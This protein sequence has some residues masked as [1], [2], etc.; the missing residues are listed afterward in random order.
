M[1]KPYIGITG[2][3]SRSEVDAILAEVPAELNRQIMIGV[4]ASYKTLQHFKN[5]MPNRYPELEKIGS[6]FREHPK[7]LNLIHYNTKERETLC[8]QLLGLAKIVGPNLHGFQLNIS[9]PEPK[10]LDVFHLQCDQKMKIVLQIGAGAFRKVDDSPEKL[11]RK[12]KAEYE[13]LIDYV[14]LDPSG[15]A[16]KQ[17]DP[18]KAKEYLD[19]LIDVNVNAA[20]GVAGG[21]NAETLGPVATLAIHFP[22]LCIDAEGRLRDKDDNLDLTLALAYLRRARNIFSKF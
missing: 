13:G 11:A 18:E 12:V 15:G 6:I 4:L 20:L 3:M 14:L 16:G 21:L 5:S 9:W 10:E 22:D 1:N 7:A 19:A 17:F 2:F 8:A